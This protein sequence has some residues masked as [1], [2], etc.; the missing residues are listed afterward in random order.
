[1]PQLSARDL[2]AALAFVDEAHSFADLD[3]FRVG[4][5]PGLG[6]LVPCDLVGY[7]EVDPGGEAL[8]LTYPEQVPDEANAELP[9]LAH[10]HP[11]ICVQLNG[12]LGAYKISDFL[13]ARQFRSL[14][15]YAGLYSK[16]GAE[17]QIAFGLGGPV[18]IG[19]AMNRD[20]RSFGERDRAMLDLL[21][22]HLTR[23]HTHLREREG[24]G[25]LVAALERGLADGGRAVLSL[26]STGRIAVA[27]GGALG[28]LQAYLPSGGATLPPALAEWLAGVPA[29]ARAPLVLDGERGRLEVRAVDLGPDGTLLMLEEERAMRAE[30]LRSLGLTRRQAEVLCLLGQDR[31]PNQI[32][33]ELFISPRTV[34]KHLE[35][36]YARLGV[37]NRAQA[38]RMAR[39]AR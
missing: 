33:A 25:E 38:L 31:S 23:A 35:H 36:I 12:D 22:P 30:G 5:L 26:D 15:L 8:V 21:R 3:S 13:S 11:L 9:R 29:R 19:I 18:V 37:H 32:A 20:R 27:S 39:A 6:R 16:I 28:L 2:H 14:E 10:E 34:R 4:I 24:A 7:N 17:D 1:M